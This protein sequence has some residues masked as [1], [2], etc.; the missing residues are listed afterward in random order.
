MSQ[1]RTAITDELKQLRRGVG[2]LIT[3]LKTSDF[4]SAPASTIHHAAGEGGLASHS[5]AVFRSLCGFLDRWGKSYDPDTLRICGLLH[6]ICKINT[7]KQ[8]EKWTK[9]SKGKWVS[10]SAWTK[11]EEDYPIGHGEKSVI[12]IQNFMKLSKEETLAIRWHMGP[13][14]PGVIGG[15]FQK[16]YNEARK[17]P[18]VSAL[19]LADM[20]ATT[21]EII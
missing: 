8:E 6:D 17:S 1:T 12:I 18:L 4:F 14:T 20:E 3:F 9:D 11:S 21:L 7:Y 5:L 19:H 10:Y 15:D 2:G 13:W 16:A